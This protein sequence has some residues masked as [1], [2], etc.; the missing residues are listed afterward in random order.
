MMPL[1]LQP[2]M[3]S[4]LPLAHFAL[5]LPAVP[6]AFAVAAWKAVPVASYFYMPETL[7]A[8]HLI[9]LGF[10]TPVALGAL[11]T[12]LPAGPWPRWRRISA[13]G[14]FAL[15]VLGMALFVALLLKKDLT[16]VWPATLLVY[17]GVTLEIS[18]LLPPLATL[19]HF[20]YS[21]LGITLAQ[22]NL[23]TAGAA[24]VL[25]SFDKRWSFLT[26]DFFG[27]LFAHAHLAAAGF[28]LTLFV[29]VAH[30]LIPM[31][32][33]SDNPKRRWGW[34]SVLGV[35]G[36]AQLLFWCLMLRGPA[37]PG[38]LAI[39][40]GWILFMLD[41]HRFVKTRRRPFPIVLRQT[42]AGEF[43]LVGAGALGLYLAFAPF[44]QTMP[45]F[46]LRY[47]YGVLL[48]AGA[49]AMMVMGVFGRLVPEILWHASLKPGPGQ[50]VRLKPEEL[51]SGRL[52][53]AGGLLCLAGT[54]GVAY[55]AF[56]ADAPALRVTALVA[57]SGAA[58]QSLLM[59]NA[60]LW[61][62][63]GIRRRRL[64]ALPPPAREP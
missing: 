34:W 28:L 19:D 26:V 14:G 41:G 7:A 50:P 25:Y 3:G 30:Q 35:G 16:A 58:L 6:L 37:W 61:L 52:Y 55:S 9:T 5:A 43:V 13:W 63:P 11:Q 1:S 12:L 31:F 17:T 29:A 56:R 8:T 49:L 42:M 22:L 21:T 64:A 44:H 23:L 62:L 38:A 33:W 53:L 36:G 15:F 46:A 39:A 32:L 54:L 4:A 59:G 60:F 45:D 2:V 24:G 48:I 51:L 10:L 27:R 57:L 40:A 47:L 18:G 20:D